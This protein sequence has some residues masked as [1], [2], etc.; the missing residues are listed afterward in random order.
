M[1]KDILTKEEARNVVLEAVRLFGTEHRGK[2]AAGNVDIGRYSMFP[3]ALVHHC[4]S[5][6]EVNIVEDMIDVS[7]AMESGSFQAIFRVSGIDDRAREEAAVMVELLDALDSIGF[8]LTEPLHPTGRCQ[9]AGEGTCA[10][11]ECNEGRQTEQDKHD[12]GMDD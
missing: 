3:D 11:C 5:C 8:H 6:G 4:D 9:C 10:W 2:T 12:E 7:K 1:K